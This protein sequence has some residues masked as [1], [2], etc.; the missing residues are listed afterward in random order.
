MV[1]PR[2]TLPQP[3]TDGPVSVEAAIAGRRSVR[4]FEPTQLTLE[5]IGQL[6]WSAQGITGDRAS[7][8]AAPSA[9]ACHPLLFY[10]CLDDG[11][12]RYHPRGHRLTQH[13]EQDARGELAAAAWRQAFIGQAPCVFVVAA[14]V[15]RTT[16]RYQRRGRL[17]YVPMDAGHAV[18]NLLLQAVALELGAVPV[19][20]F[21]DDAVKGVLALPGA[22]VPLYIV[23]V[24]H[25]G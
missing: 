17:R 2:R 15:E 13:L 3:R 18:E 8:R 22:E 14:I 19:G 9:G 6:L 20:A 25:P 23:P 12:W 5:E 10:A 7:E 16:A 1:E 4:R 24:G 21:D 11:V